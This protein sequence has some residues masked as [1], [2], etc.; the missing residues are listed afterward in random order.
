MQDKPRSMGYALIYLIAIISLLAT[1]TLINLNKE[2][3]AKPEPNVPPVWKLEDINEFVVA[4]ETTIDLNEF[5]SDKNNDTIAYTASQPE[6]I[7][8][9]ITLNLI[10]LKADGHNFNASIELTASDGD[11]QTKK[12]VKLIVPERKITISLE[13]GYGANY[14]AEN[15]GTE[16]ISGIIDLTV[17]NTGFNW[18]AN[19]ENLCTRW[20][21]YSVENA[22]S[23]FVCYGSQKCC[24]FVDLLATRP[25]WNEPFYS[26]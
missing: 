9:E 3:P 14:D 21:T 26:A 5:F 6:N 1:I 4:G 15:D 24:Q 10:T 11:K 25:Q 20:E 17:E 2:K 12:E 22:E 19:Q 18:D 8:V 7:A 16:S 23:T 13:Y